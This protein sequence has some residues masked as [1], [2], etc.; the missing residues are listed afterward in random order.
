MATDDEAVPVELA[1]DELGGEQLPV[2]EA[3]SIFL[4]NLVSS[5]S[6]HS[7]FAVVIVGIVVAVAI[8]ADK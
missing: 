6:A 5:L 3:V 8:V 4:A 7:R 2:K 1:I